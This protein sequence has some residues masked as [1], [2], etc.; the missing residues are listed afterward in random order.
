MVNIDIQDLKK[1]LVENCMLKMQVDQIQQDTPLFGPDSVGLDSID[2][3][4]MTLAIEKTYKIPI[5][6]PATAK[7]ALHSLGKLRDWLI[8]QSSKK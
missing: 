7:E 2:A 5:K 6:D 4:Q 3:L 8:I 1:L